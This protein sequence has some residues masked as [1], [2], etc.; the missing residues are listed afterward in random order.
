MNWY[1]KAKNYGEIGH[2]GNYILW[3]SPDG[4]K[5]IKSGPQLHKPN[6]KGLQHNNWDMWG[7]DNSSEPFR[8][9]YNADTKDVSVIVK[10]LQDIP[11]GL[12]N[13]LIRTF[14]V[15]NIYVFDGYNSR[16]TIRVASNRMAQTGE[17][18]IMDG[19]SMFADST[20]GDMDHESY[21]INHVQS[22]YAY[23]EFLGDVFVDWDAFKRELAMEAFKEEF[24]KIPTKEY[25]E[26]SRKQ[27]QD[28]A[29]KKLKE[30]GMTDEEYAI[31][32]GKGDARQYGMEHLG[33]KRVAG[34]NIQTYTLTSND[35]K[36]IADGLW[37]INNDLDENSN[38][39]FNIEV[40]S[41]NNFYTDV[42]FKL[43]SDGA[44]SMLREFQSVYAKNKSWYKIASKKSIPQIA[45]YVRKN[46]VKAYGDEILKEKCLPASKALKNE[47]I[48]NG[49]DAIVIKGLFKVDNPDPSVVLD[50]DLSE[51]EKEEAMFTPLHYWVEVNNMIVDITA[52]QFN[53]ELDAPL[54]PIVIGTYNDLERYKVMGTYELV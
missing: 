18:W 54:N 3:Y 38:E 44:P 49:Y 36:N 39:L 42:P 50:D 6:T 1:K 19:K 28:L 26:K 43:I 35:L 52:S 48:K 31:A 5:V 21:V 32:E 30:I 14:D 16:E 4:N 40:V 45:N 25:Y 23:D 47:L 17:W 46:L 11:Q 12:I 13:N 2:K 27:M 41:T 37:D 34:S 15:R 9:R 8:G 51:Q 22:K 29:I 7:E 24:G 20:I 10:V 33:W 53:N